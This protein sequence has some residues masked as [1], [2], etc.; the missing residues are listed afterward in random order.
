MIEVTKD[1]GR[2]KISFPYNP[3][4]IVK[5]KLESNKKSLR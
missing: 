3:D 1:G 4:Y 5:I 2:V